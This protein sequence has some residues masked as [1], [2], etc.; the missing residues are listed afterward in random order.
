MNLKDKII[1][2][3]LDGTLVRNDGKISDYSA[4]VI[5]KLIDEGYH[6]TLIT[7]RNIISGGGTFYKCNMKGAAV[8]CNGSI[9]K[10]L[11]KNEYIFE[12]VIPYEDVFYYE[13]LESIQKYIDDIL[14]EH[15]METFALN[16]TIFKDATYI[17]KFEDTLKYKPS[18]MVFY[19]K[20]E[21]SNKIIQDIINSSSDI[22]HY[23]YWGRLGEFYNLLVDKRFG[24]E[25]LCKYYNKTS[26]DLVFF[27]DAENDRSCLSFA[28]Y[29]VAMKNADDETKKCAKYITDYN[30]QEDG[31]VKFLLKMIEKM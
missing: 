11:T 14:V 24:A 10:D 2:F 3:D 31:A 28:K 29:G 25:K 20:D 7:G 6:I 26:D 8:F 13:N 5:S 1:A 4:N 16:G 9:V 27:G 19:A 12:N 17:G 22:Y 15:E 23:R 18:S 30:N 21:P